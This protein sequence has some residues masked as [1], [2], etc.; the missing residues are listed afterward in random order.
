[1][2]YSKIYIL[3]IDNTEFLSYRSN[4]TNELYL[5]SEKNY[6]SKIENLK[7]LKNQV[8]RYPGDLAGRLHSIA[9]LFHDLSLFAKY[10][11]V[12]LDPNSLVTIFP[13]IVGSALQIANMNSSEA[14]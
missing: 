10:P 8:L 7:D 14:D 9:N 4:S 5:D 6:A 2:G 3:G 11:I 1:M 12:N 13:K